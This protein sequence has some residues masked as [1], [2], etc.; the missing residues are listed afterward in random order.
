MT[1]LKTDIE[2]AIEHLGIR[3]RRSIRVGDDAAALPRGDGFD[4]LA[5]EGMD[6]GFVS[7]MPW[8]AGWSAV[9][10]N[11]SDIAAMGGSARALVNAVWSSDSDRAAELFAGMRAACETYDVPMVGGHTNLQASEDY[12]SVAVLGHADRLL[13]SFD[14]APGQRLV[15]A[16]DLRGRWHGDY[17]FWDAAT[18][19]PPDRLRR[20]LMLLPEV[21]RRRLATAAKDISQAGVLGTATMLAETSHVGVEIDLSAIPAPAGLRPGGDGFDRWLRAF[22]SF[23]FLLAADEDNAP[24]LVDLF[25]EADITAADIGGFDDSQVVTTRHNGTVR[26]LRDLRESPLTGCT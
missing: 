1:A 10:V 14:A 21:A 6:S 26:Q 18:D 7:A 23:G 25:G 4:L 3:G 5:C 22:P 8:F 24:A 15:M 9:M 12:L 13:T 16:V 11:L 19:A 17:P 2:T 20:D